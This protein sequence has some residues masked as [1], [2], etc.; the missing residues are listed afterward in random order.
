MTNEE[1]AKRIA[2]KLEN[3]GIFGVVFKRINETPE[4]GILYQTIKIIE[5]EL[6]IIETEKNPPSNPLPQDEPGMAY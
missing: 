4:E 2:E 1:K 5:E 6:E 3:A